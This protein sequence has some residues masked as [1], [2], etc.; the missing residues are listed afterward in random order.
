MSLVATNNQCSEVTGQGEWVSVAELADFLAAKSPEPL[1]QT[2]TVFLRDLQ[3]KAGQLADQGSARLIACADA[4]V[5]RLL[6]HDGRLR[7]LAGERH[8]VFQAADAKAVRREL[9]ARGYVLPLAR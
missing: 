8:L 5:A 2:V 6:A 9:R 4:T 3:R 7:Q 1:P